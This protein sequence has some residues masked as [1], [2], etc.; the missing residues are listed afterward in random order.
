MASM[1]ANIPHSRRRPL[2][3]GESPAFSTSSAD[4]GDKRKGSL[5]DLALAGRRVA[6]GLGVHSWLPSN[7]R[8]RRD[9]TANLLWAAFPIVAALLFVSGLALLVWRMAASLHGQRVSNEAALLAR[10]WESEA[11]NPLVPR[12]YIPLLV[13]T[14][15]GAPETAEALE[16]LALSDGIRETCVLFA[17]DSD[18]D[19]QRA[20]ALARLLPAGVR[21]AALVRP[22]V[23]TL[24]AAAAA[25]PSGVT[26][27]SA[28]V[29]FLLSVAFD[30]IMA[31]AAVILA[32]RQ[33]GWRT[34]QA[35]ADAAAAA[36]IAESVGSRRDHG[37]GTV[38]APP[39]EAAAAAAAAV[40][41]PHLHHDATTAA[42][43]AAA[44][45][46]A[47]AAAGAMPPAVRARGAAALPSDTGP[48][49]AAR[50]ALRFLAWA[51]REAE[52]L[53]PSD[54]TAILAIDA[55]ARAASAKLDAA[56]R[57][58][59]LG[60]RDGPGVGN[61]TSQAPAE[62][63]AAAGAAGS[64]VRQ[65]T[66]GPAS[67]GIAASGATGRAV[68]PDHTSAEL[69][70]KLAFA[71]GPTADG[72]SFGWHR[73]LKS[74]FQAGDATATA[75]AAKAADVGIDGQLMLISGRQWAALSREWS[76]SR[77]WRDEVAA[78]SV[79]TRRS[80]LAPLVRRMGRGE[81]EGRAVD[82]VLPAASNA[83]QFQAMRLVRGADAAPTVSP[84]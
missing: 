31:P 4:A 40:D 70:S 55:G 79:H 2:A 57:G 17:V 63:A 49:W 67:A 54:V 29:N 42:K 51:H 15:P 34:V 18:T 24:S 45:A 82:A 32:P 84:P 56:A 41:H 81:E 30:A 59:G 61:A 7:L 75:K 80:V 8:R 21:F 78:L 20:L 72:A 64:R 25:A 27:E 28:R 13:A 77:D 6:V 35:A 19:R 26:A 12:G 16:A 68:I 5:A 1:T 76:H 83:L 37:P 66:D 10:K 38:P 58:A 33:Q 65:A 23:V 47:A 36:R 14:S 71:V 53:T 11:D 50:D 60:P 74:D 52:R 46:A 22:S 9:R 73:Q 39:A 69:T 43:V 48:L 62:A 3:G 44:A